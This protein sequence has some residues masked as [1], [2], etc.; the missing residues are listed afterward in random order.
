MRRG[1]CLHANQAGRQ[2]FEELH[3]LAAAKLP[4][5]DGLFGRIDAVDLKYVLGNIQ[6]DCGNLHGDG[7]LM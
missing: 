4:P 7:S 5:D 6:T 1:T 3:H 2:R